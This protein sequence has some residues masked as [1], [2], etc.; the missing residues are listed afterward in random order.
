MGVENQI[1][2]EGK[3][4]FADRVFQHT[5]LIPP[6]TWTLEEFDLEFWRVPLAVL[7][8]AALAAVIGIVVMLRLDRNRSLG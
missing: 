2:R 3:N 5:P 6:I 8:F 4:G 7:P 1:P